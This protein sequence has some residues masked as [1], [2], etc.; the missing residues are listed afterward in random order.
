MRKEALFVAGVGY[1]AGHPDLEWE[2]CLSLA[3][4]NTGNLLIGNGLR[5]SLHHDKWQWGAA[6]SPDYICKNF[7]RIISP[8][9]NFLRKKRDIE[10]WARIVEEVALPCLMVG[11]GA[12]SATAGAVPQNILRALSGLSK[13]S[14]AAPNP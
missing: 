1:E 3:G 4:G 10:P 11:L 9:A 6:Y 14:Q 12:E 5:L 7:D 8:S 2:K 13:R